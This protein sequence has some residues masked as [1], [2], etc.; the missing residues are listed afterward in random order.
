MLD[1]KTK[2]WLLEV[3]YNPSMSANTPLDWKI[4]GDAIGDAFK[5]LCVNKENKAKF[6]RKEKLKA[7]KRL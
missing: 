6:I 1:E 4:K 7:Q 3:N 2:P 5:L